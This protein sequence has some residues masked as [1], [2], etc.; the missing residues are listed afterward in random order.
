MVGNRRR[1]RIVLSPIYPSVGAETE[2]LKM[3]RAILRA[4][5]EEVKA[6]ILPM[7]EAEMERQRSGLVIDAIP[8]GLW[9]R[10]ASRAAQ[11]LTQAGSLVRGILGLEARRHTS[12][13]AASVR[14][15]IGIDVAAVVAQED[16]TDYLEDANER[17]VSLITKLTNDTVESVKTAV[18][19]AILQG[20]TAKQLRGELTSRFAISD[21]RAKVI[22]RDQVSK[23]TS[24]LNRRRHTQA[25]IAEYIWTTSHDERV[26]SLHKSLDGKEYRYGEETGAE[27]GLPPGQP[28][29][30]RCVARAI[31]VIGGERF[32]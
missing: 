24:D 19:D 16:L 9:V 15:A 8:G 29:Q 12:K 21:R 25:G 14:S 3:L 13:W 28:I 11:L 27:Q 32:T 7:V 23:L 2:Y 18:M 30:C 17:N 31:V 22:A 26:R 6:S 20:K 10:F 1:S 4:L 5:S